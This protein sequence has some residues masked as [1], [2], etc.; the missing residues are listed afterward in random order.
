MVAQQYGGSAAGGGAR[1][2]VP[3]DGEAVRRARRPVVSTGNP[4]ITVAF[5]F[6]KVEVREPVEEIRDLAAMVWELAEQVAVLARETVPEQ[7]AAA[8]AV[9]EHAALLASRLGPAS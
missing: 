9:A 8:D 7:A 4:R 6:S 2:R 5:P 1:D 3:A